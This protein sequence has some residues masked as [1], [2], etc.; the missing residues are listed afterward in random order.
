MQSVLKKSVGLDTSLTKLV[1]NSSTFLPESSTEENKETVEALAFRLKEEAEKKAEVV[2]KNE[3]DIKREL[4]IGNVPVTVTN[5][6]LMNFL[7]KVLVE[8]GTCPDPGDP[9]IQS[10]MHSTNTFAFVRFRTIKEANLGMQLNGIMC[11]GNK[12]RVN[13]V[14]PTALDSVPLNPEAAVDAL[15]TGK[16]DNP[17][18]EDPKEKEAEKAKRE[19]AEKNNTTLDGVELSN[20]VT[21][22]EVENPEEIADIKVEIIEECNEK[23]GTV[24]NMRIEAEDLKVVIQMSTPEETNKVLKAMRGRKFAGREIEAE[25]VQYLQDE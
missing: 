20:M 6:Q 17:E 23:Y 16:L 12:L 9:I 15:L 24:K 22:E 21:R 4:H 5:E 3:T 10:V 25:L 8:L 18:E 1:D 7:N 13:R 19:E 11:L 14:R 2:K